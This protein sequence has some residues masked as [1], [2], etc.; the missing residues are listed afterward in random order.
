MRKSNSCKFINLILI[1]LFALNW[2]CSNAQKDFKVLPGACQTSEY[3][4]LLKGKKVGVVVNQSSYIESVSLVDTLI[5]SGVE[6]IKIYSPEHGFKGNREDGALIRGGQ[7][8]SEDIPVISLYGN[9]KKPS[10]EN[11]ANVEIM[12]FDLQDI[13]VRYYTY[14][15]TM[16]YVMESCAEAGIP[17]IVLDRPNPNGHYVDGPFLE[18]KHTSFIGMHP[19]PAVHGMTAGEYAGMINGEYWLI[20]SIQC[21][22]TVIRCKNYDHGTA[23]D[24]PIYPSP[25]LRTMESVYLYPSTGIL[26]GTIVSEGRGTEAPFQ[27]IG[28]PDF[29]DKSFSFIPRSIEGASL[30]PKFKGQVCYGIDLRGLSPDSLR[31][32]A[33]LNLS[34]LIR[35]YQDLDKGAEFFTPYFLLMAGTTKLQEQI[36]MG[37]EADQIRESW[38]KDLEAYKKIRAKYLLYPDFE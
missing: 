5:S 32:L 35:F 25:N 16:H 38:V 28:H 1:V 20:D 23:Y 36:M 4:P 22:L 19:V 29:S 8:Y 26:Q 10:A 14:L 33:M 21:D 6:L 12:V 11:L 30:N 3:L 27:I 9:S 15:S 31:A 2:N 37:L 34:W 24:L 13:G 7:H 18:L 17:L